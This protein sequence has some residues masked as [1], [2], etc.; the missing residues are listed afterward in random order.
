MRM[1]TL[2][3]ESLPTLKL[4]AF[5]NCLGETPSDTERVFDLL[6]AHS[7]IYG[8][9]TKSFLI[10][11]VGNQIAKLLRSQSM[12]IWGWTHRNHRDAV[13]FLESHV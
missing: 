9:L 12:I 10:V 4:L 13:S 1:T 7:E 8:S 3:E 6:I 11:H 5:E 2:G